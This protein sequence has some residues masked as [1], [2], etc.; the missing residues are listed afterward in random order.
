MFW[1]RNFHLSNRES[2]VAAYKKARS[3]FAF[4]ESF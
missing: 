1:K 2:L 3:I 4:L